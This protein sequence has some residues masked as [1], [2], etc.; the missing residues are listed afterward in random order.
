MV[1]RLFW[2]ALA[3]WLLAM[4][5]VSWSLY[6]SYGVDLEADEGDVVR[7]T[8]YRV[9]WPGNG[10]IWLG[11]GAHQRRP[12]QKPFQSFDPAASAFHPLRGYRIPEPTNVWNRLGFWWIAEPATDPSNRA[13]RPRL[14]WGFWVGVPS[15]LP[16]LL[17]GAICVRR[18]TCDRRWNSE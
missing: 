11:G 10:G 18:R 15:W 5:L 3:L 6:T 14:L 16:V 17:V 1:R 9:R 8:Y 7:C 4:S 13:S 2:M 12:Q